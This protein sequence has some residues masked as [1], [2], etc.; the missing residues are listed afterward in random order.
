MPVEDLQELFL[1]LQKQL[2]TEL[3]VNREVIHHPGSKG[4]AS[5][6][7]WIRMF[8]AHMPMRYQVGKAFVIDVKGQ[9]SEQIDLVLYDRQYTPLLF[10]KSGQTFIPAESVYAVFEVKQTLNKYAV[11]YAGEKAASVRKLSRTTAS[12]YH[13]GGTY[14]PKGLFAVLA[15]ILC[16]DSEWK[17]P[18]GIPL[19]DAIAE[20]KADERLDFGCVITGGS[21]ETLYAEN[22]EMSLSKHGESTSLVGLFMGLLK[23][24]QKLG[25]VPAIDLAAYEKVL[26][27]LATSNQNRPC[28]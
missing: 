28:A 23:R 11:K 26:K 7:D 5:E 20:L 21:F 19:V 17:P 27:D 8:N 4:D 24:L 3:R 22:N 9:S 10:N 16:T 6:F 13:A 12:I 25:T 18:L 15:G 14:A 2:A 1:N